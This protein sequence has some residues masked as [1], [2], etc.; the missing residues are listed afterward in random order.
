MSDF[1]NSVRRLYW[2]DGLG[3]NGKDCLSEILYEFLEVPPTDTQIEKAFLL[4]PFDDI[5]D[6]MK[7]GM[8]DTEVRENIYTYFEKNPL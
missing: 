5:C 8:S 3:Q 1:E 7:F 6:A 2:L 4:I